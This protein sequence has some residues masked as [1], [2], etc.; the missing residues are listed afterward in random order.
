[1]KSRIISTFLC[2]AVLMA[3]VWLVR[4]E[5]K[6]PVITPEPETEELPEETTTEPSVDP[7]RAF[8]IQTA[9]DTE[10]LIERLAYGG[11]KSYS[12]EIAELTTRLQL[13]ADY[14]KDNLADLF[15]SLYYSKICEVLRSVTQ[16]P[17][18]SNSDF[19]TRVA[20]ILTELENT[21]PTNKT[22]DENDPVSPMY[23]PKFDTSANGKTTLALLSVYRQQ[24]KKE[25]TVTLSFAGNLYIGDTLLGADQ[26][27]SF[28]NQQSK[29]PYAF[30]LYKVSAVLNTD[31]ASFANL[32]TPLTSSVGGA[33]ASGF[34]KGDPDYAK[35]LKNGG[36]DV[37]SLSSPN[38]K[39]FGDAGKTDTKN[40]LN[41]AEIKFTDEG[42]VCYFETE[43]GT[44]A[45]LTYDI[46]D[47]INENVNVSYSAAPKQDIAAAKAAGAKIVVVQFNWVNRETRDW[48]PCMGQVYS[49]R[50]AIDSGANLVIGTHTGFVEA[51]ER[52]KG[53]SIIYSPGNLSDRTSTKVDP[54]YK[55]SFI[56]EQ[57]FS[58]EGDKIVTGKIQVFPMTDSSSDNGVPSLVLDQNGVNTFKNNIH[59]WSST[60]RFGVS[61][62]ANDP[63][64]I[65]EL[66]LISINKR[67]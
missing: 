27:G 35:L 10:A 65:D 43:I 1:M 38:M 2:V 29:T 20:T 22:V 42:T 3:T 32:E 5:P 31:T 37:L 19:G 45:Y 62:E 11:N 59:L 47:E 16:T 55:S 60:V 34:L 57:S 63:F 53:C 13:S 9:H 33:A 61:S 49:A 46:I 17:F 30:P 18:A 28:K 14:L 54:E 66:N 25:N 8:V 36:L 4:F 67:S 48:D 39:N 26:E 21:Y 23:Y 58:L 15:G 6:A 24:A 12:D 52:Y 41:S 64:P 50:A 51:I 40:A 56:F 7:T 44:V